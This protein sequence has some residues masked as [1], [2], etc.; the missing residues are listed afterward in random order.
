MHP[1]GHS[2]PKANSD[3][4]M[5][6]AQSSSQLTVRALSQNDEMPGSSTSTP[7]LR[8]HSQAVS[9]R[10]SASGASY[11]EPKNLQSIVRCMTDLSEYYVKNAS[12][13]KRDSIRERY[14]TTPLI[15]RAFTQTS[16]KNAVK[17]MA[18]NF[19]TEGY[20]PKDICQ[21]LMLSEALFNFWREGYEHG[22]IPF[23][24]GTSIRLSTSVAR[25]E[26]NLT[27]TCAL[28]N[29]QLTLEA[30]KIILTVLRD[31]PEATQRQL[32][33]TISKDK[34]FIEK[35]KEIRRNRKER[36]ERAA[37]Q[38]NL[39]AVNHFISHCGLARPSEGAGSQALSSDM[40]SR[41]VQAALSSSQAAASSSSSSSP[42]TSGMKRR[43][44]SESEKASTSAKVTRSALV[45]QPSSSSS[46]VVS[47][48]ASLSSLMA[49]VGLVIVHENQ[50]FDY[51]PTN[52]CM[53]GI[54]IFKFEFATNDES[55]P[56]TEGAL[57]ANSEI[58]A[59]LRKKYFLLECNRRG[60]SA[61]DMCRLFDLSI[62]QI[63][64]LFNH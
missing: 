55:H 60:M 22:G 27:E 43:A 31:E 7:I 18:L 8:P 23:L 14:T 41:I 11:L 40:V 61:Q 34:T 36:G 58:S 38:L 12:V 2:S 57:R 17:Y 13:E 1:I 30:E 39:N 50:A 6:V 16:L 9:T 52:R 26:T 59:I 51:E 56:V 53:D 20:S 29:C 15:S 35:A 64:L 48:Q 3:D 32:I 42:S 44:S 28:E 19:Y 21:G 45:F 37:T 62:E 10:M 5:P 24:E 47:A 49:S 33:E 46:L 25:P 63:N 54:S 4:E